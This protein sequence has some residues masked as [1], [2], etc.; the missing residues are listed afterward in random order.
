MHGVGVGNPV[1][2]LA[3]WNGDYPEPEFSV[4]GGGSSFLDRQRTL[5]AVARINPAD[6]VKLIAGANLVS[7]DSRG[8]SYGASRSTAERKL[9][10]YV[11]A[12]VDLS[13]D[14]SFYAS[15]SAIFK[16]QSELDA[17]LNRLAPATGTNAE[18][19]L[20]AEL[21]DKRVNASVAVFRT[22]QD[23]LATSV[24][25]VN[26]V[27]IHEGQ[28]T[29]A[30]GFELE[31]AGAL[32]DRLQL[33]AGYTQLAIED[34]DGA[35]ARTFTPRRMLRVATTYRVPGT[36]RLK[37]GATLNAQSAI[38][39]E[40]AGGIVVRQPGYALLNLMARYAFS[41]SLSATLNLANV[42][43]RRYVTSLYWSQGYYGAPRHGSV[44]LQWAY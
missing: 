9:S 39:R 24:G 23:K 6:R 22:R 42:T 12:V 29:L 19:G 3:S 25:F 37:V 30:R 11:G 10:P 13:R 16:P 7:I 14:W 43:D 5:Y 8:D 28:D 40:E 27:T 36:D 17:S 20:K 18:L 1:P 21:L 2:D 26:G 34:R 32:G 41:D 38:Y 44:S 4:P 35:P 31:L 15:R 33:Q